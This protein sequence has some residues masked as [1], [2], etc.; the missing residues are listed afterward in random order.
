MVVEV[1]ACN[2]KARACFDVAQNHAELIFVADVV[3]KYGI[4]LFFEFIEKLGVVHF[5]EMVHFELI[6]FECYKACA[7]NVLVIL[8]SRSYDFVANFTESTLVFLNMVNFLHGNNIT[9]RPF[10]FLNH[11]LKS[12]SKFE[13]VQRLPVVLIECSTDLAVHVLIRKHIICH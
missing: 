9:F 13:S 3:M 10:N 8:P 7:L 1:R 12:V 5:L 6:F 4:S 11:L 2:Y